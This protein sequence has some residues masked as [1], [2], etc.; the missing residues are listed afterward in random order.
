M[1][2]VTE[3]DKAVL[4]LLSVGWFLLSVVLTFAFAESVKSAIGIYILLWGCMGVLSFWVY[5]LK[6]WRFNTDDYS[7]LTAITNGLFFASIFLASLTSFIWFCLTA[8]GAAREMLV[9]EHGLFITFITLGVATVTLFFIK[10]LYVAGCSVV[11]A[12]RYIF[13]SKNL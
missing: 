6:G 12:I 7:I 5:Y 3:K 11:H 10:G 13:G 1:S 8:L 2:S 4:E 9:A